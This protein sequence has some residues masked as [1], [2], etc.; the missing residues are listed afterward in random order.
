MLRPPDTFFY[1][2]SLYL[3]ESDFVFLLAPGQAGCQLGAVSNLN[4]SKFLYSLLLPFFL[5]AYASATKPI[6]PPKPASPKRRARSPK[7][8][9]PKKAKL[10][11]E[12]KPDYTR[13]KRNPPL[14]EPTWQQIHADMEA[15]HIIGTYGTNFFG[16]K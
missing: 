11:A 1:P 3:S 13:K 4:N 8:S 12:T 14:T 16:F 9:K 6:M 15:G 5:V 10:T 2:T 7:A